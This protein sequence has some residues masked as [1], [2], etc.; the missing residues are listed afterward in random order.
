MNDVTGDA[1]RTKPSTD[2][3]RS[4]YDAIDWSTNCYSAV[5]NK[6]SKAAKETEVT[7]QDAEQATN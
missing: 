5:N 1:Q 2:L 6:Q 3:F 7:I 4:G